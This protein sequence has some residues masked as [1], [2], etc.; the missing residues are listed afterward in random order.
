MRTGGVRHEIELD[1]LS[2]ILHHIVGKVRHKTKA[3]VLDH[4]I[5]LVL[6]ALMQY[7]VK[8]FMSDIQFSVFS[9]RHLE[10]ID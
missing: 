5:P 4:E 7:F 9:R 2:Y 3:C 6:Q 8:I 10:K 1:T